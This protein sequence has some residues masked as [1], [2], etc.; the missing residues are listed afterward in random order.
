MGTE[1][2]LNRFNPEIH[3]RVRRTIF[4]PVNIKM[5]QRKVVVG[6]QKLVYRLV[7]DGRFKLILH[8]IVRVVITVR[9]C[10]ARGPGHE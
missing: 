6:R 4:F 5:K 8:E 1:V 7:E 2:N 10:L 3:I 9:E